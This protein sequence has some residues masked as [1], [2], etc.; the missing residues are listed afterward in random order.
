MQ[1]TINGCVVQ[2]VYSRNFKMKQ[3]RCLRSG[4]SVWRIFHRPVDAVR[5]AKQ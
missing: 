4:S 5:Y 2:V 1:T 3:Y